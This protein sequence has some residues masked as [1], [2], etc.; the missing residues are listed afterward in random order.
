M[1]GGVRIKVNKKGLLAILNAPETYADLRHRANAIKAAL[2]TAGGEEWKVEISKGR[3]RAGVSVGANNPA[4]MRSA[5]EDF[6]L[7]R[8]IDAGR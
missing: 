7:Q 8:A 2:P 1:A 3:D 4:A 5:A 6:A